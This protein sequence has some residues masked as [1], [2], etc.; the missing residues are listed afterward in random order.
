MEIDCNFCSNGMS[1]SEYH[2]F[3][4]GNDHKSNRRTRFLIMKELLNKYYN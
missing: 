3:V 4:Q 2:F 1:A